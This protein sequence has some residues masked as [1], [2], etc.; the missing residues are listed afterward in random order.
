MTYYS[1]LPWLKIGPLHF[2]SEV[3]ARASNMVPD[4]AGAWRHI[5]GSS[6]WPKMWA[7]APPPV[8]AW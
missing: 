3:K 5:G 7:C 6:L 1:E 4:G 2:G 8:R